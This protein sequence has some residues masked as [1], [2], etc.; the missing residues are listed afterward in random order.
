[1]ACRQP[2]TPS[3]H[4]TCGY[5]INTPI[6]R[7]VL[8]MDGLSFGGSLVLQRCNNC[9]STGFRRMK[10]SRAPNSKEEE[11]ITAEVRQHAKQFHNGRVFFFVE[12]FR[13]VEYSSSSTKEWKRTK[14]AHAFRF[15][16]V[17]VDI[18]AC[19]NHLSLTV[20]QHSSIL[21]TSKTIS[22]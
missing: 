1:M 21:R 18:C 19:W 13:M 2:S 12:G 20:Q 14:E 6:S 8:V 5:N 7:R 3:D 10:S 4:I 9:D 11:K 16:C 15:L 22:H 17:L